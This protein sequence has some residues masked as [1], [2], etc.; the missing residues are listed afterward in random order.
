MKNHLS[1]I[2]STVSLLVLAACAS[3]PPVTVDEALAMAKNGSSPDRIIEA[4][5]TS[6]AHYNLTASDIVRL[7]ESGLPTPVLDYMQQTQ[8]E[9]VA[10]AERQREWMFGPR[11]FS[12]RRCW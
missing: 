8:L 4:M 7:H 9:A 1:F 6:R 5:K 2:V 10:D 3:I 11:C 12:F